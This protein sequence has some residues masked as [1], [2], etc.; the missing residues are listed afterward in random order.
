MM[1]MYRSSVSARVIVVVAGIVALLLNNSLP[2]T[3][4]GLAGG[5]VASAHSVV[6][7]VLHA[8]AGSDGSTL[9]RVGIFAE[10]VILSRGNAAVVLVALHE[11]VKLL[12]GEVF[13]GGRSVWMVRGGTVAGGS[14]VVGGEAL[15]VE[16][17]PLDD[18]LRGD[19]AGDFLVLGLAHLEVVELIAVAPA[20]GELRLSPGWIGG[21]K[22]GSP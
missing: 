4:G 14:G 6:N 17:L 11:L 13:V 20:N 21:R 19:F 5:V 8:F 16:V 3:R 22:H 12:L 2:Y 9:L 18:G 1:N 10:T 7:D 15:G